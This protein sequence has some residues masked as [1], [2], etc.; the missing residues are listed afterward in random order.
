MLIK[1]LCT[2]CAE[3]SICKNRHVRYRS[4]L[5]YIVKRFAPT[6]TYL[7]HYCDV[8]SK[9]R[10]RHFVA[11]LEVHVHKFMWICRKFIAEAGLIHS[12][13]SWYKDVRIKLCLHLTIDNLLIWSLQNYIYI[14]LATCNHLKTKNNNYYKQH[15]LFYKIWEII[16]C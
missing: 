16:A 9:T 8:F 10:K 7:S 13:Y 3:D 15:K 5:I 4:S 11:D 12:R 6:I 14:I 2:S 1:F